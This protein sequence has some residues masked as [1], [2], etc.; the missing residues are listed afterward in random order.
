MSLD[1]IYLEGMVFYA[2]HGRTQAERELGQRFVVD[3][4]VE[5]DLREAG[6]S[7]RIEDTVH[8]ARLFQVVKEVLEGPPHSLLE[9]VAEEVARRILE[10]FPRVEAVWLRIGKP[11]VAIKGSVLK[12]AAVAIERRREAPS[13]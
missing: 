10:G 1:S 7:D 6:A 13:P 12:E 4:E 8:Y 9:S 3:L 11:G 5:A 2:Y